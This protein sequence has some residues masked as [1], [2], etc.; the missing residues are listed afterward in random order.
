MTVCIWFI[1]E[2]IGTLTLLG[3]RKKNLPLPEE[4]AGMVVSVA[5]LLLHHLAGVGTAA[6]VLHRTGREV[7]LRLSDRSLGSTSLGIS[8]RH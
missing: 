6:D 4:V 1:T 2:D 5:A 7:R 3:A 8:G